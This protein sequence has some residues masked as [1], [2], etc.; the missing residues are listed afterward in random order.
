VYPITYV[1]EK[2]DVAGHDIPVRFLYRL[3]PLVELV[4][5]MRSVLYDLRFPS[6]AGLAYLALWGFGLTAFGLWFFRR[7][8]G[9]LAEEV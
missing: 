6:F 7:L 1:P 8:D 4:Q 9:R 3:N 5:S 2:A